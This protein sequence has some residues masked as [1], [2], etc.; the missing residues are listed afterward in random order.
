MRQ[1][2]DH[3]KLTSSQ[4]SSLYVNKT[5]TV[6]GIKLKA[7]TKEKEVTVGGAEAV[8]A[9]PAISARKKLPKKRVLSLE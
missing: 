9:G 2:A 3:P 6:K 8:L 4:F 5:V 1:N 7:E